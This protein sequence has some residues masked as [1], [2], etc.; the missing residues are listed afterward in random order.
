MFAYCENLRSVTI[1]EGV[2]DIGDSTFFNCTALTDIALPST[3]RRIRSRA[4]SSS[5]LTNITI[6]DSVKNI[7]FGVYNNAFSDCSKLN[8]ASQAVLR[9]M[10]YT[11]GFSA[12]Q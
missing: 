1:P 2:T 5:S 4:F 12:F 11:G 8:L 3:I 6:P 9:R 10:G 7:D